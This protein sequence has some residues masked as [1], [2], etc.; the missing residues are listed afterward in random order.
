MKRD[1]KTSINSSTVK[2][3]TPAETVKIKHA[4]GRPI[5]NADDVNTE[6]AALYE[7]QKKEFESYINYT[8]AVRDG[9]AL[10]AYTLKKLNRG[11]NK[12]ILSMLDIKNLSL[13]LGIC[14]D[15]ASLTKTKTIGK[16][17]SKENKDLNDTLNEIKAGLSNG[18]V[19]VTLEQTKQS[20]NIKGVN[21]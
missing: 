8:D 10:I 20:V 17:S 5:K 9:S 1:S 2:I 11:K 16:L 15:K 21:E 6:G 14:Q 7:A 19:N 3:L 13:G 12:A 4:G 18:N